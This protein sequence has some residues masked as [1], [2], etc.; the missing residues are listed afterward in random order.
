MTLGSLLMHLADLK[1]DSGNIVDSTYLRYQDALKS[2]ERF[3][4][5]DKEIIEISSDDLRNYLNSLRSMSDSHIHKCYT[6]LRKVYRYA[7]YKG[8]VKVDLMADK[9]SI[10]KPV[11][12]QEDGPVIALEVFEQ[13][14][15]VRVL[16]NE[17]RLNPYSNILLLLLS[18][19][20]RPGEC[21]ALR[22][23]DINWSSK[24]INIRRSMTRD[25]NNKF[26]IGNKTKTY[27]SIRDI[28]FTLPIESV[29]RDALLH[30][31]EN[32]EDLLFWNRNT[33][34][35]FTPY[36]IYSFCQRLNKRYQ[37]TEH[38]HPNMLRHTYATRAIESGMTAVVLKNK[39][40]HKNILVTLN[41]YAHVFKKYEAQKDD[42]LTRYLIDN[43]LL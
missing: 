34:K 29:L 15:L 20:M 39:L 27:F 10:F 42:E 41:T 21:L 11:S 7:F 25:I 5:A 40:G 24:V 18:T 38:L 23:S 16:S 26:V 6:F 17:E 37:I 12:D 33:D 43:G 32:P 2:F 31:S 30:S 9:D 3:G 1:H 8:Y 22:K 13:K 35:Y 4:I 28:S 19:G 36:S 14:R